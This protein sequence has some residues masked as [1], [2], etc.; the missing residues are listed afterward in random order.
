MIKKAS[1]DSLNALH[2]AVA[3]MLLNNLEDPKILAQAIMF[4]K[5]NNITVDVV[6]S[7]PMMSLSDSIKSIANNINTET[8]FSVEDM[9]AV[10]DG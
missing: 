8:K 2:D 5:N 1:L 10:A 4:L 7:T 9:L 3:N 6:E